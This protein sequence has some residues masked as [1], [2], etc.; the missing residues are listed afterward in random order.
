MGNLAAG[1]G[2]PE[3]REP[4]SH[5]TLLDYRLQKTPISLRDGGLIIGSAVPLLLTAARA[6][7]SFGTAN[8]V[9]C[10]LSALARSGELR[11]NSRS[12]PRLLSD[13]VFLVTAEAPAQ[14]TRAWVSTNHR[15]PFSTRLRGQVQRRANGRLTA[16]R[17]PGVLW[18]TS[19]GSASRLLLPFTV[20]ARPDCCWH[21]TRAEGALSTRIT[22]LTCVLDLT[23]STSASTIDYLCAQ[24]RG[25][26]AANA[27]A[28]RHHTRLRRQGAQPQERGPGDATRPPGRVL[29]GQRLWQVLH[30][31][32]HHLRRG[33]TALRRVA[34]HVRPAVLRQPASA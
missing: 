30:G 18:A 33:P 13:A 4:F 9:E 19:L 31:L 28:R 21:Y 2:I 22:S 6:V 15:R 16:W 25:S 24:Q 29:R 32:R 10:V 26:E 20:F 27:R 17:T 5:F 14:P 3:L 23:V 1:G 11:G 8:S 7:H 34:L 12:N